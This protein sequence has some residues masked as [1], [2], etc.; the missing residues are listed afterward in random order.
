[1]HQ[2]QR[3]PGALS[4]SFGSPVFMIEIEDKN[5]LLGTTRER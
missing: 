1:M 4:L 3:A 2:R 5:E